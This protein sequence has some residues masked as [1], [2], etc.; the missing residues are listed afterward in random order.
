MENLRR[1]S[2]VY[3]PDGLN[4]TYDL[5]AASLGQFLGAGK[6]G[7]QTVRSK[8]REGVESLIAGVQLAGHQRTSQLV[9]T[10]LKRI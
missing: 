1:F 10:S 7:K 9:M 5:K 2:H 3:Y 8:D 6:E 4:T